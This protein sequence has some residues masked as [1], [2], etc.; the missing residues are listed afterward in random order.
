VTNDDDLLKLGFIRDTDGG[1]KSDISEVREMP[2]HCRRF[3]ELRELEQA[4]EIAEGA[5][6]V[7]NYCSGQLLVSWSIVG[8]T[9]WH[10][11]S[12]LRFEF[13]PLEHYSPRAYF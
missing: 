9:T 11:P 6:E 3:A 2:L 7:I 5:V 8:H 12:P 10:A 13:Q 4:I 1:L